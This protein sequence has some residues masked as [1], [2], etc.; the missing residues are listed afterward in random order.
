MV[1]T[2]VVICA[3]VIFGFLIISMLRPMKA[4]GHVRIGRDWYEV[5]LK[6]RMP[7]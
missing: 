1:A 6:V 2:A 4:P 7:K 5:P 3:V